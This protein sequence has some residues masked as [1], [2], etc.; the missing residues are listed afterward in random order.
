[1]GQAFARALH[2]EGAHV[3]LVDVDT[4]GLRILEQQL[5]DRATARVLDVADELAWAELAAWAGSTLDRVDA[6]VNCAGILRY[7]SIEKHTL[8]DFRAV[9]DINLIGTFLGMRAI[10]PLM[11][12]AGRGSVINVC[13]TASLVGN[14]D[15]VG[16]GASKW[17]VRG[18]TKS[19]AVDMAG[20]GV[21]VNA[22][23]PGFVST[24]LNADTSDGLTDALPIPR[25][26]SPAEIAKTVVF[27]ASDESSYSTGA[28]FVVD[29]GLTT[30]PTGSYR[31]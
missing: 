24:E 31:G 6:L 25:Y 11:R 17:A 2:D 8:D 29:G 4:E 23:H 15:G 1:M 3:V 28:D 18:L 27:L 22:L 10:L 20:S 5:G 21:R 16:Y 19:A 26:A 7:G 14:P 9:L 12:A 13:S 30:G